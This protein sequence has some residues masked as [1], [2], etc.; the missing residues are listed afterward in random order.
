MGTIMNTA[1]NDSSGAV[2][3]LMISFSVQALLHG[4]NR[5]TNV[6]LSW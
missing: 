2:N 4:V 5:W 3:F 6:Y 1:V